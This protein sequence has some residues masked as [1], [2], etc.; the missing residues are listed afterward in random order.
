[1]ATRGRQ[2][3][4]ILG[5]LLNGAALTGDDL[6]AIAVGTEE[7]AAARDEGKVDALHVTG[8]L[9]DDDTG[10]EEGGYAE[11]GALVALTET[12][13]VV[14]SLK[15]PQRFLAKRAHY[16]VVS[17]SFTIAITGARIKFTA[18]LLCS[19]LALF[20]NKQ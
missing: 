10:A 6:A 19:R 1:V 9:A 11:K 2:H 8:N 16:S 15:A 3:G 20:P 4:G 7:C 5:L 14:F 18:C 13:S 17:W 12:I